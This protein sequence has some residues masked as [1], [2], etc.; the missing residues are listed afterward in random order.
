MVGRHCKT[1]LSSLYHVI[2]HLSDA[3]KPPKITYRASSGHEYWL[4]HYLTECTP[5]C[6]ADRARVAPALLATRP[7]AHEAHIPA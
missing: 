7:A 5:M 6:P 2:K 4:G 1:A 3:S